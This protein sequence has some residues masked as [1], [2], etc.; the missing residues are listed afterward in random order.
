MYYTRTNYQAINKSHTFPKAFTTIPKVFLQV[1]FTG[2]W[3]TGF[4]TVKTGTITKTGFT[5]VYDIS[6]FILAVGY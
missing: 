4:G 6:M 1:V 2:N 3:D 5:S